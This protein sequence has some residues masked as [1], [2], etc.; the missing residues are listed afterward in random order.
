MNRK[1]VFIALLA[2]S[3][4]ITVEMR[5]GAVISADPSN[6]RTHLRS[7]KPG[8]TLS[9]AAGLYTRLKIVV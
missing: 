9:L 4:T 6:Y 7:L 2:I 3:L 5:G 8:D 1:L